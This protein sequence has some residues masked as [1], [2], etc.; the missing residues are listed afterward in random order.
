MN[1]VIQSALL[2]FD[3]RKEIGGDVGQRMKE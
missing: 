1:L 3:L 2:K